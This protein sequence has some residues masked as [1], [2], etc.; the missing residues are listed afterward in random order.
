VDDVTPAKRT[1]DLPTHAA[2]L[3][4][5]ISFAGFHVV[6]KA[7][8][9]HLAPLAL[10][11]ARVA[12]ATPLLLLL[13]R[14][15]EHVT[16]SRRDLPHLA[17]LGFLGVFLNQ[18]MYI[19]GLRYTSATNAAIL[20][21]SIPVF[22][23]ALAAAFGIERLTARKVFGVALAVAGAVALLDPWRVTAL[24]RAW[25]GNLL[26]LGN[27]LA[28]ASYLVLLRPLLRRLPP[29]TVVAWAFLLGGT[30]TLA[31]GMPTV[32]AVQPGALPASV[33]WGLA[34]I[35]LL[36]TAVN[37]ALNSWAVRRSSPA[38]VA[39]YTTLQPLAAAGLAVFFLHE[40]PGGGELLGFALISAGLAGVASRRRRP[41]P[42]RDP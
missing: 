42:G 20:M 40:S 16:P 31:V 17:L 32:L 23:V 3:F 11:A 34:Y 36:P 26:V 25:L 10:A 24:D 2:L 33:W 1:A 28:Y 35:I 8:L 21:P 4:V 39:T 27:C 5:Q 12:F 9:A 22:T 30:A 14:R 29:L 19:F 13:A 41:T 18:L 38:L 6:A 15:F 37:Y 7:V